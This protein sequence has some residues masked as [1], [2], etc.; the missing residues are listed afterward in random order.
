MTNHCFFTR[1]LL[2]LTVKD[3]ENRSTFGE[4]TGKSR[5]SCFVVY[6]DWLAVR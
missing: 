3:F 4:V 6:C 1:L 5:V 2:S